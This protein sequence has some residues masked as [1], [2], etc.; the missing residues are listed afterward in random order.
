M[1]KKKYSDKVPIYQGNVDETKV[2]GEVPSTFERK[3]KW[4][5]MMKKTGNCTEKEYQEKLKEFKVKY[6]IRD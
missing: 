3:K 6:N 4:L 5:D 1:K 2:V